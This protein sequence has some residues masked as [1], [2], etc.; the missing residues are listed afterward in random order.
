[1][2]ELT[3]AANEIHEI[4]YLSQVAPDIAYSRKREIANVLLRLKGTIVD[5]EAEKRRDLE[6]RLYIAEAAVA[7][8]KL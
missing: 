5:A 8:S 4:C 2:S 3:E 1:M 6:R 7:D